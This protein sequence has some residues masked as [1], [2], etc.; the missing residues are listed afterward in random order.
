MKNLQLTTTL[1]LFIAAMSLASADSDKSVRILVAKANQ[2]TAKVTIGTQTYLAP[3]SAEDGNLDWNNV[4]DGYYITPAF[5]SLFEQGRVA[6][7]VEGTTTQFRALRA[8]AKTK[9]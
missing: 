1:C 5:A 6:I 7:R 4:K 2:M 3:I 9:K 8:P